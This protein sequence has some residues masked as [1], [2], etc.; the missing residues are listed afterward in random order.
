VDINTPFTNWGANGDWSVQT[1]SFTL[2]QNIAYLSLGISGINSVHD[3]YIAWDIAPQSVV[4][5][6]PATALLLTGGIAALAA[7]RRRKKSA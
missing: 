5:P 6:E 3:S 7:I 1:F 2:T 4:V